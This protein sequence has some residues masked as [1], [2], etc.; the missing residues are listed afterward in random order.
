MGRDAHFYG[1]NVAIYMWM[2][3]AIRF[4]MKIFITIRFDDSML[5]DMVTDFNIF[6]EN[7]LFFSLFNLYTI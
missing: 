1:E 2:Y 6:N 5:L 7:Y 4:R 3:A